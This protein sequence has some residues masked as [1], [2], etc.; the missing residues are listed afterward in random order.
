[1]S[2][3]DLELYKCMNRH[4]DLVILISQWINIQLI[5]LLVVKKIIEKKEIKKEYRVNFHKVPIIH[6]FHNF[7]N[8]CNPS[9]ILNTDLFTVF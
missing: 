1:M 8:L 7:E 4:E 3:N 5:A 9:Q 6:I 2:G